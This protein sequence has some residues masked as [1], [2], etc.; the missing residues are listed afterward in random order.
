MA[1]QTLVQNF[2]CIVDTSIESASA[3]NVAIHTIRTLN[4]KSVFKEQGKKNRLYLVHF[5][6]L[7]A[8]YFTSKEKKRRNL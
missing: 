8:G 4:E 1:D 6:A 2:L 7:K 3:F 5:S